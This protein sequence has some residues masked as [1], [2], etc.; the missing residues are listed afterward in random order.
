MKTKTKVT[1]EEEKGIKMIQFLQKMGGVNE[2]R[3]KALKNWRAFSDWE[4]RSTEKAYQLLG[5]K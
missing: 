5:G 2:P 1:K 4:K 3:G